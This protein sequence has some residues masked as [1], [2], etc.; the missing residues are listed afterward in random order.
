MRDVTAV[1]DLSPRGV[2]REKIHPGRVNSTRNHF[3]DV[4]AVRKTKYMLH[5]KIALSL[6]TFK[7]KRKTMHFYISLLLYR[8]NYYT[9]DH[10]KQ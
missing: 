9:D 1:N 8:L 6:Y 7:L 10:H 3:K 2:S 4:E 5:F